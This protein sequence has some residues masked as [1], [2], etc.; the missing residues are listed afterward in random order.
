MI[1]MKESAQPGSEASRKQ[2]GPSY[3]CRLLFVVLSA[4]VT[5]AFCEVT[6]RLFS[7]NPY[8]Y[9]LPERV[10]RLPLSNARVNHVI[11]RSVIDR[12]RPVVRFRTDERSY[13]LPSF[14]F[15]NPDFTVAFLG[16]STTE[17]IVVHEEL[18]FPARVSYLLEKKRMK[19]N[20]L[21]AGKS[22]NSTHDAI[23]VLINH[24]VQDKPDVVVLME[25]WNDIGYLT[26]DMSYRRRMGEAYSFSDLVRFV[27]KR[28]STTFYVAALVRKWATWGRV[29][30][31]TKYFV[32]EDYDREWQQLPR[33]EYEKR[34]R[35]FVRVSRAFGIEPVLMTQPGSNIRNALTP[36]WGD[37]KNQEVFNHLIRKVGA[38]EGAV[39]IDLVRYLI[40]NVKDWNQPMNIFYDGVHVTDR[41]SEVYAEYIAERL[42]N[43]VLPRRIRRLQ[44]KQ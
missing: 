32:N 7:H 43:E 34:L 5:F 36:N 30:L 2:R 27:L 26:Q 42:Y 1:D 33:E 4:L 31:D 13:I 23:N 10:L 6:L 20:T 21:N 12:E 25:A 38:E 24:V 17:C 3:W 40:E 35:V 16:G 11:D 8:R 41:G 15:K 19:V 29:K 18:R 28:A 22:G 44:G 14:R 9:E 37:L 39:V